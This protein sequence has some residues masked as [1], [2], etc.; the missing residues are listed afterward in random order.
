M[1]KVKIT[2]PQTIWK[3]EEFEV[4]EE[5]LI[6]AEERGDFFKSEFIMETISQDDFD[7]IPGGE[8]GILNGLEFDY[9]TIKRVE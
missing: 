1:P 9:V 3:T 7:Q 4:D 5:K 2:Y 8:K 6:I